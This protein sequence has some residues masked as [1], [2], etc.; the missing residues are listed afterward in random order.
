MKRRIYTDEEIEILKRNVM[1]KEIKYKR[2]IVYEPIFKMWSIM[3]RYEYPEY[4]AKEIFEKAGFN[5]MILHPD[6]PRR[7]ISRWIYNY[8]KFGIKY[9]LPENEDYTIKDSFKKHLLKVVL[10]RLDKYE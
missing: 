10:E 5:T 9:F 2:E 6:L 8:K 7:R 3:M 4:T 1:V